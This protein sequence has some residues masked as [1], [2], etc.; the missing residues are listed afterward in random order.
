MS[1]PEIMATVSNPSMWGVAQHWAQSRV[2]L[3][4]R[5]SWGHCP[6]AD[7][8]HICM[9]AKRTAMHLLPLDRPA[10]G[11]ESWADSEAAG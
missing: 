7:Y 10:L 8:S 6:C 4:G 2:V 1:R 9:A 3:R 5:S 11:S